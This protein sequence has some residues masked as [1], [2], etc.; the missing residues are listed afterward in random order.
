[1]R[2]MMEAMGQSVPEDK[3]ILELNPEHPLIKAVA[4]EADGTKRDE[5]IDLLYGQ[6]CLAEGTLPP[7]PARFNALVAQLMGR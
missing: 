2:R 7:D 1:M 5:A 6:A 3:R 4:A